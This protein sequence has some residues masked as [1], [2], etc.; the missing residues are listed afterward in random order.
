MDLL[1]RSHP[2]LSNKLKIVLKM[3][4]VT[5]SQDGV[6]GIIKL[7]RFRVKKS[8]DTACHV[9]SFVM[10]RLAFAASFVVCDMRTT[11]IFM[12]LNHSLVFMLSF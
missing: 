3:S 6:P 8:R 10:S 1:N 7:S 2:A 5:K 11:K 9:L 4:N 12:I